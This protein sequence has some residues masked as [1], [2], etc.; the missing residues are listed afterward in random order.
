M[1]VVQKRKDGN[2]CK[3]YS[4]VELIL[5]VTFYF[6]ERRYKTNMVKN[7]ICSSEIGARV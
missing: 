1:E 6:L 3:K 7:Y 2:H 4:N 5:F